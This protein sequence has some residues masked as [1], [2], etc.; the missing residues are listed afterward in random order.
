MNLV[1]LNPFFPG[2]QQCLY[3]EETRLLFVSSTRRPNRDESDSIGEDANLCASL[4]VLH[5]TIPFAV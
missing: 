2:I 1:S 5:L 3:D 4:L